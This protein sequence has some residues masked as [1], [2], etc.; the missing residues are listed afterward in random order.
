MGNVY[1]V[2][3]GMTSFGKFFDKSVKD[4]TRE[5]VDAALTDADAVITDIEAAWFSNTT[6]GVIEGQ[7]LVPGEM[8]LRNMG[9][10]GIP[11]TNVENACASASTAL[12]GAVTAI[13]AG[14]VE[15]AIAVGVDKMYSEDKSKSFEIFDGAIDVHRREEEFAALEKLG[16]GV[17]PPPD[18][19]IPNQQRSPFMD[20]YACFAKQHMKMFD[21]TQR[22][23]AAVASKNHWHSTMNPKS[24]FNFEAS[25]DE[26]L[27]ARLISW[28]LTLPMCSPIS[29]GGA[30]AVV[31]SEDALKRFDNKR[32]IRILASAMGTGIKRSPEDLEN[33]ITRRAAR[34]AYEVAGIGP[35]E[36]DVAEVHDA[37]AMGEITQSE[38]LGLCEFGEGGSL[39]ESGQSKLGGR[40]P[41]NPSGGLES[42]G[43]PIGATGLGQI[44]ELSNQLRGE[45]GDRQVDGARF[46]IAENGGG[47]Y[48]IEEATCCITILGK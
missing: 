38:C 6:Q 16:E 11:M 35:G 20:V 5:A 23:L 45:C 2:G 22:Q 25:I 40:I 48:G 14:V 18:E 26:V 30:A 9:F 32:A 19:I 42:K 10:E 34:N 36:I 41:I 37:T 12:N 33:H 39:A 46:A 24:Q 29:D 17:N 8:A 44:Y 28:P 7:F 15:V 1:L 3:V 31:C 47:I 21:L 27:D 43:H 4:L 13:K